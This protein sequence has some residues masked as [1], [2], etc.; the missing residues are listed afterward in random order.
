M[1]EIDE[2]K[3]KLDKIHFQFEEF[4]NLT[5]N[6]TQILRESKNQLLDNIEKINKIKKYAESLKCENYVIYLSL[7]EI[8]KEK[9]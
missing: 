1:D 8:L 6:E 9:K 5:F 4:R 7:M 2:L 3:K